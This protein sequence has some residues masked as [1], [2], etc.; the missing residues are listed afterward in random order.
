MR[1][2]ALMCIVVL[3]PV[4]AAQAPDTAGVPRTTVSGVV[5]DSIA[6][7]P[8]AGAVVQL[9][10]ADTPS[11]FNGTA[12]SDSLGRFTIANVPAGRYMLGFFHPVLDS[13]GVEPLLRDVN[14]D[15]RQPVRADLATP[16]PSRLRAAICG[17]R[18]AADTGALV[19]G[20]V[21]DAQTHAAAKGVSVR[22]T[23]VE[24]TLRAG[25]FD[26]SV[27]QIL[28]TTADNGWFAMCNVPSGGTMALIANRG[29]DSTDLI[30]VEVPAEGFL[31]RDLYLGPAQVVASDAKRRDSLAPPP[32]RRRAGEGRLSGVV[33]TVNG[34]R[35]IAD[36]LV[37]ILDGPETRANER[38]EWTLTGAPLGTRMLE[39][40]SVGYY[41][42]RTAV[43]VVANGAPVRTALATMKDVLDT[44]KVV[45]SRLA[46][47][48][49]VEF[50]ARRRIGGGR[51]LTAEDVQ[52]RQPVVTSDLFR[53]M[54]GLRVERGELGDTQLLMR[55]TFEET[56]V[57][58]VFI[59]GR[60]MRN[61]TADDIDGWV[62][63]NEIVGVE[64]YA[65]THVPA[66]FNA[67]L[68]GGGASGGESCGSIVIWTKPAPS[69]GA[70]SSWKW[71]VAQALGLVAAALGIRA[72]FA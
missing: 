61:L 39:V 10:G 64:I 19:V 53:N 7:A 54:P 4:A 20:V 56:C 40:R 60:H 59:D 1:F 29:A 47:Q 46:N 16:S 65:G 3:V 17:R 37:R 72:L 9:V 51:Y 50:N 55:G 21:R 41:P 18:A 71:R 5:H 8:L 14:V 26:R 27:P 25:R 12:L 15:G 11:R 38:G 6:R 43:D 24:F 48:N 31:R 2:L 66:Q 70:G 68:T 33:V 30:E 58:S 28:V 45:A 22:G 49:L 67:G 36:A 52:R 42:T 35:A 44:V 69:T 32:V 57:P 34:G 23:W 13:L 63:P 62:K